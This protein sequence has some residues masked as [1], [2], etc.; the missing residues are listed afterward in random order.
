MYYFSD[1][2]IVE[3]EVFFHELM[4]LC[5]AE[6]SS[7]EKLPCYKNVKPLVPLRK[8][9]YRALA[10]CHYIQ[11]QREK[12]FTVLYKALEKPNAELQEAAFQ[13]VKK[14]IAGFAMDMEVVSFRLKSGAEVNIMTK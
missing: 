10:A 11:S 13:C 14:F 1:L 9:A 6:D 4:A 12:I 2:S 7:L 5:E 8:S 3:H